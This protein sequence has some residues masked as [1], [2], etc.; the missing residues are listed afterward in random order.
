MIRLMSA[1]LASL[2]RS[3]VVRCAM[4][5]VTKAV[6]CEQRTPSTQQRGANRRRP[7][8]MASQQCRGMC[9]DQTAGR[10]QRNHAA[11][12]HQRVRTSAKKR[13][14]A[15]L[16]SFAIVCCRSMNLRRRSAA[17]GTVR[18]ARPGVKLCA[19]GRAQHARSRGCSSQ[20]IR[21]DRR[22]KISGMTNTAR[23]EGRLGIAPFRLTWPRRPRAPPAP[24]PS[25]SR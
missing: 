19:R 20:R 7:R 18:S 15:C 4:S 5:Q 9:G 21:T 8:Q 22:L 16:A 25:A 13:S 2:T 11:K 23:D 14:L 3:D 6:R 12:L 24:R 17:N 1:S 10:E